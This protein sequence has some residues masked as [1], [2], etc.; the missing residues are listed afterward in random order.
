MNFKE[1]LSLAIKSV[2]NDLNSMT[3]DE[4]RSEIKRFFYDDRTLA[5]LYAWDG[6]SAQI[7]DPID[8]NFEWKELTSDR[9][10]PV[11]LCHQNIPPIFFDDQRY[12]KISDDHRY[13]K[14]IASD[15]YFRFM[16]AA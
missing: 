15:D 1:R 6:V 9:M 13:E 16:A 10:P 7:Y 3:S 2:F 14:N 8:S 11:K 4:F 12:E 5:L